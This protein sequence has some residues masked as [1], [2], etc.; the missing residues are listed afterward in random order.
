MKN[1]HGKVALVTGATSGI[2][3]AIA[4]AFCA[5]GATVLLVGRNQSKLKQ[6]EQDLGP[7]AHGLM[8]DLSEAKQLTNMADTVSKQFPTMDLL[9]H[10]AGIFAVG[11]HLN[12]EQ[13]DFIFEV[14]YATPVNLTTALLPKLRASRGEVV[15][16]N[17]SAARDTES[18]DP[19]VQSK[20]KLK[21]YADTLRRAENEQGI[22]VLS[23]YPGRTATPMQEQIFRSEGKTYL[24]EHLLQPSDIAET[25]LSAV[26]LPRTAEITDIHIR[27]FKKSA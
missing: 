24:A 22:R 16:I 3:E 23:V 18:K 15:F 10:A 13:V 8:V 19:Y 2:G 14:N 27:P 7:S 21:E 17:S 11:E 9:V 5:A 6:M 20:V 26:L 1:L 25:V 12:P 4:R